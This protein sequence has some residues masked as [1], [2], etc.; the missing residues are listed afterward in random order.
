[1][2]GCDN[3]LLVGDG[4]CNDESNTETCNY[5]GG[6]CCLINASTDYC[7]DCI[8]H[9]EESCLVGVHPFVGDGYCD[10][11]TNVGKC[12]YDGGDCCG[13][14][15]VEDHCSNCTC[16]NDT[17]KVTTNP[18]IGD[19]FCNHDMNNVQ[20]NFDGLDCCRSAYDLEICS[21]CICHGKL[22]FLFIIS[23]CQKNLE[24]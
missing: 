4:W 8:C 5:D 1:M 11:E 16:L 22:V 18:L 21:D 2:F 15:V 17:K 20:C 9:L 23:A 24:C 7:S 19:G 13:I 3:I 14:C 12:D 10:D 6:D